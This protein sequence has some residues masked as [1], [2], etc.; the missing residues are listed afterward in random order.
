MCLYIKVIKTQI[1]KNDITCYKVMMKQRNGAVCT[2][3]RLIRP[4]PDVLSGYASFKASHANIPAHK[5]LESINVESWFYKHNTDYAAEVSIGFIHTYMFAS[6]AVQ[7]MGTECF[8]RKEY[9]LYRCV[10]PKGTEYF[11]GEYGCY[12]CYASR[13]IKFEGIVD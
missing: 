12:P 11:V 9:L 10:I 8:A 13:E 7:D 6:H 3:F 5:L 4:N 2:P 1:A